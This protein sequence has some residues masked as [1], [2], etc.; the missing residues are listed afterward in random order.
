MCLLL[1]KQSG[2]VP[3][4]RGRAVKGSHLR[5]FLLSLEKRLFLLM[6]GENGDDNCGRPRS[7]TQSLLSRTQEYQADC[8]RTTPFPQNHQKGP[9]GYP[10][11]TISAYQAQ[12][13]SCLW[14]ISRSCRYV[15][16]A[17]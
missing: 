13:C 11:T 15:V 9:E 3:Q 6:I 7:H 16:S 5:V 1:T 17:K 4:M 2:G 14:I 8:T 12:T 10:T